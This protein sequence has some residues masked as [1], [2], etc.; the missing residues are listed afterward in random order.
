M[1]AYECA[2]SHRGIG[3]IALQVDVNLGDPSGT[4][5]E[6]NSKLL[7]GMLRL[8][9]YPITWCSPRIDAAIDRVDKKDRWRDLVDMS[10]SRSRQTRSTTC[11]RRSRSWRTT[12]ART[13]ALERCCSRRGRISLRPSGRPGGATNVSQTPRPSRSKTSSLPGPSWLRSAQPSMRV[14]DSLPPTRGASRTDEPPPSSPSLAE[15]P[16]LLQIEGAHLLRDDGGGAVTVSMRVMSAGDGFRYLM[17]TVA[18]GDGERSMSTPL[19][20]YYSAKGTPPG[21]WMGSGLPGLGAGRIARVTRS[22]SR[23][24]SCSSGWVVIR[25]PGNRSAAH[26]RRTSP[27]P[28]AVARS[29]ATTSRSRFRSRR[30]CSGGLRM[31]RRRNASCARTMQRLRRRSPSSS[32]RLLPHAPGQQPATAPL[33]RSRSRG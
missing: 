32:A 28:V 20:R 27:G 12:V 24:C 6:T 23:S 13:R 7:G 5:L 17:R 8:R 29:P 30:A 1:S 16:R 3:G 10:R 33:R 15:A 11:A 21:R 4:S 18:A 2:S 19:T 31:P 25:S 14:P 22:P 26:T 9:G